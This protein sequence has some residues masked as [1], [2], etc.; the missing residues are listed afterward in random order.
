[1][2]VELPN[3]DDYDDGLEEENWMNLNTD[4]KD[5]KFNNRRVKRSKTSILNVACKHPKSVHI[6]KNGATSKSSK[7]NPT[8][9]T[10]LTCPFD[11]IFQILIC[12]LSDY[13]SILLEIVKH[14]NEYGQL[15]QYCLEPKVNLTII[16]RMRNEILLKIMP[17][18][19]ISVG[20]YKSIRCDTFIAPMFEKICNLCPPLNSVT[21]NYDCIFCGNSTVLKSFVRFNLKDF[22]TNDI[23]KSIHP[24]KSEGKCPKCKKECKAQRQ[25]NKIIAFDVDGQLS[26]IKICEIQKNFVIG[27]EKFAL[28]G[29]IEAIPGHF[30]AHSVRLDGE[31]QTYDDLQPAKPLKFVL[32]AERNCVLLLYRFNGLEHN[33]KEFNVVLNREESFRIKPKRSKAKQK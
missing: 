12:V 11:S 8:I 32:Q 9:T 16:N 26:K 2:N 28:A 24:L 1:M 23:A 13:P 17:E 30:I 22:D 19:A 29:L 6:L 31:W 33:L 21:M 3:D 25:L 27:N 15:M 10:S 14:T 4:I 7:M 18:K 20:N 5:K